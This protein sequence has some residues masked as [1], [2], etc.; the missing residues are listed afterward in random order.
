LLPEE[1]IQTAETLKQMV[2][3]GEVTPPQT[4]AELETFTPPQLP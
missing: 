1:V 3:D 4:E 2:V